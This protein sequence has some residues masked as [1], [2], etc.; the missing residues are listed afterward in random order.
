MRRTT[1]EF[2]SLRRHS[3]DHFPSCELYLASAKWL[4]IQ[5]NTATNMCGILA[6][7]GTQVCDNYIDQLK[8]L[9][10]ARGP[11][12]S[13]P[14]RECQTKCDLKLRVSASVLHLRGERL[15][16]QPVIDQGSN[17]LLFN[18]Q[19]YAFHGQALDKFISDTTFLAKK[20][21]A[22]LSKAEIAKTLSKIDGPFAIIYWSNSLKSLF[23]GR[24]FF[25][26]K[27]L[28]TLTSRSDPTL[29][30]LISS[31]GSAVDN[32]SEVWQEVDSRGFH[33]L[34]F[35]QTS[36]KR[37]F[38]MWDIDNVYPRTNRCEWVKLDPR[39]DIDRSLNAPVSI[40]NQDL[41]SHDDF[42]TQDYEIAV[43]HLEK[44]LTSAVGKRIK[45]NKDLCLIC[46]EEAT[47]ERIPECDHSKVAVAFSGGIDS[48][49]L[50][51]ALH[52]VLNKSETIDLI[53][54]AFKDESPDRLSVG[55]AFKELRQLCPNRNWR[56]VICD[57]SLPELQSER[58]KIIRHLILPCNTVVDDGLGC[59]CW[60]I[61]RAQ[62][63]SLDSSIDDRALESLFKEFL[64]YDAH[65]NPD[66]SRPNKINIIYE[67]PATMLFAGMGID[68]QLGGYTSHRAAWSSGGT[69]GVLDEIAFQMRRIPTRNLGRDDRTLSHHGR[70]IKLPFLDYHFVSFLNETPVSLKM[71][72]SERPEFGPKKLLRR[73]AQRWGL[74]GTSSRVKRALQFGT[75]IA[76]L[77]DSS[78][79]GGDICSRLN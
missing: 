53:T 76:S 3:C 1:V 22:C 64:K 2:A 45:Y 78:E 14:I 25:G 77:E 29:P 73:L 65:Y 66:M 79:K 18:G 20:L 26:R 11:D 7:L 36:M 51:L 63:R 15:E 21:S 13:S 17:V 38:F 69:R 16:K 54:V 39:I 9:I 71:S 62:G 50:A 23:Y 49:M 12:Y 46:R 27:S 60:F 41:R 55:E 70:D 44:L 6:I 28:C 30:L 31:V 56:L 68:E 52:K 74:T 67:S 57:I 48:T 32:N 10:D 37:T 40:L 4:Q 61:S 24:D 72:L 58:N 33:C 42:S 43:D 75:R 35:S 8:K 47:I 34:D 5:A 19:I 59:G